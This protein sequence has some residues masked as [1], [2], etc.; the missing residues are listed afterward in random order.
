V[1]GPIAAGGS[2]D[3]QSA[4]KTRADLGHGYTDHCLNHPNR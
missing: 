1:A 3:I 2:R 4:V